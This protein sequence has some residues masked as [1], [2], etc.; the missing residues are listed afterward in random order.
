[1]SVPFLFNF[2]H[3]LDST[4]SPAQALQISVWRSTLFLENVFFPL[5]FRSLSSGSDTY[6]CRSLLLPNATILRISFIFALTGGDNEF[7]AAA[8]V[9]IFYHCISHWGS[10]VRTCARHRRL[11]WIMMGCCRWATV[12]RND[13][14]FGG[15]RETLICSHNVHAQYCR[16]QSEH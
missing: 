10:S 5:P 14:E 8:V 12:R 16:L 2:V 9:G 15:Q 13:G 6:Q 11:K 1:M 7:V 4:V 3:S